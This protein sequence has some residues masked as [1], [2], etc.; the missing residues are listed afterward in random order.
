MKQI[1]TGAGLLGLGLCMVATALIITHDMGAQA[2]ASSAFQGS[3]PSCVAAYEKTEIHW[4]KKFE[5]TY[6]VWSDGTIMGWRPYSKSE[7]GVDWKYWRDR[8]GYSAAEALPNGYI[9]SP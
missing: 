2:Y 8:V 5:V 6:T 4:G 9:I 1:S 7:H 3:S